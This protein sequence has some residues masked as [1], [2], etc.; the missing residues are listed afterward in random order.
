MTLPFKQ[1]DIYLGLAEIHG[2]LRI[3]DQSLELEYK[4]KDTTL[5]FLD[6]DVKS[7]RI[8]LGI[9]DSIEV[10]K[11]WFSG[12]FDITLN[13][14]PNLDNPFQLEGNHLKLS[15]KK[16]DL[17]KARSFR[18]KLMYEILERK[19]ESLDED[20]KKEF[21]RQNK[22]QT[23]SRKTTQRSNTDGLENMLRED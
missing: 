6:S 5:G 15:V 16:N 22:K 1:K 20:E 2:L 3:A 14:I 7:C 11:K 8:P 13:R 17:E 10:E 9:I 19:L 4:V 18:S 23:G 12:F 21:S